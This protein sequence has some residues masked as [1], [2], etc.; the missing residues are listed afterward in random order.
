MFDLHDFILTIPTSDAPILVVRDPGFDTFE[1][2]QSEY[3]LAVKEFGERMVDIVHFEIRDGKKVVKVVL[4]DEYEPDWDE[5]DYDETNYDPY[6]GED[7]YP[8]DT[9]YGYED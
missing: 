9:E 1:Y 7:F 5:G 4:E 3:D 8:T 2:Y 6:L